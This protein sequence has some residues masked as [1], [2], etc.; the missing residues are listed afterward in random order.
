MVRS[1]PLERDDATLG[2]TPFIMN[3]LKDK[4]E[5]MIHNINLSEK[6]DDFVK[7]FDERYKIVINK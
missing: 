3:K 7:I 1:S 6:K 4:L 2:A 5:V